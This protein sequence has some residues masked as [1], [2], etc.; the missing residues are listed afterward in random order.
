MSGLARYEARVIRGHIMQILKVAYPGPATLEVLEIT[1]SD[2]ACPTSPA[3]LNGYIAYL[4]EKGYVTTWEA[5][6]EILG[7]SRTMVKLTATGI[8]L[9]EGNI[10]PDPGVVL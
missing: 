1:L 2:R 5:G 3:V 10:P 7:I 8:D 4:A 9:L 6:D